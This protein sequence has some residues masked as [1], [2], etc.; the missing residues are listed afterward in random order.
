MFQYL[1]TET[2]EQHAERVG[3]EAESVLWGGED[4]NET[5]E[6]SR[7]LR[8][9]PEAVVKVPARAVTVKRICSC[10]SYTC[11]EI[12]R[13]GLPE[14]VYLAEVAGLPTQYERDRRAA[15]LQ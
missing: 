8:A 7:R 10:G 2:E 15:A 14:P 6:L 9:D 12:R 4:E 1:L 11:S 3:A 13:F 5:S